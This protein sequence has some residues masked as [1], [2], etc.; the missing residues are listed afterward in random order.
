M[1]QAVYQRRRASLARTI[2]EGL[3][4][5]PAGTPKVRSHDTHFPFRQDSDFYYLTGFKECDA[6]LVMQ[7]SGGQSRDILLVR[8]KNPK[9]EMWEGKRLGVEEARQRMGVD[10]SFPVHEFSRRLGEF[11]QGHRRVYFDLHDRNLME[12]VLQACRQRDLRRRKKVFF[13]ESFHRLNDVIGRMRLIKEDGEIELMKR[14]AA[15]SDVA[16][17]AAMAFASEG[18]NESEVQ[19]LMDYLFRRHGA[20]GEAYAS[21]VAGGANGL[22]LHYT[23]NN[24]PLVAG[25]MLL[26]DA[27]AEV[28]YYAS[29]VTRTFPVNGRYTSAQR[30][31]YNLVLAAQKA[32]FELARPGQTLAEM[33]RC[34]SLTLIQG[35]VELKILVGKPEEILEKKEHRRYYPHGTG[36]WLGLDVH[37]QCPY[38]QADLED[39]ILA[40]GM[41]FTVEPGLYFPADD[42]KVPAAY[43]GIAVRIED[44]LLIT[45]SGHQNLT[46]AIP[47]EVAQVEEACRRDWRELTKCKDSF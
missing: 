41:A 45:E 47:K 10:Q 1:D 35:L 19:N 28:E 25:D 14:A 23:A 44:D 33:H 7:I 3:A 24:A 40:P 39:V 34:A 11:M 22:V 9:A 4:I 30:E 13:P 32:A 43:R 21:I 38:L 15:A 37:D 16:H 6:Y 29:D 31:I 20:G 5:V 17:R 2:G 12:K 18:K 42:E 27:G 36:H 8:P 26:I 46:A